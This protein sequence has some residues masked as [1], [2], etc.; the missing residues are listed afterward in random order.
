M[1]NFPLS[2]GHKCALSGKKYEQKVH[3]ILRETTIDGSPFNTQVEKELGC[4]TAGNDIECNYKSLKDLAIELK[5][6]CTPDWMQCSIRYDNVNNKWVPAGKG[7]IPEECREMFKALINNIELYGGRIPPFLERQISYNDWIEIKSTSSD[8]WRDHYID[9][10]DTTIS[11]M[12]RIKGC[13]YI[14]ISGYGLYHTG[15]DICNFQVPKFE[16]P[17]QIRIRTK[18]HRREK[19]NGFC[20]MSVMCACQPKD[21]KKLQRSPFSLDTIAKLPLQLIYRRII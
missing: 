16:A 17:Q 19:R 13:S 12:Y 20:D 11:E 10:P 7:R 2:K 6:W 8:I 3:A 1:S 15:E 5:V 18:L 21:I 9:I 4:S 14:Q